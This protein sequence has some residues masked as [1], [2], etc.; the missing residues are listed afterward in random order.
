MI[1]R[2]QQYTISQTALLIREDNLDI[3]LV[4][5]YL[6][7]GSNMGE[8]QENLQKALDYISQRMRI[9]K[10]SSIYDTAP[11]GNINQPRF[12]NMVWGGESMKKSLS[13]LTFVIPNG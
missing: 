6:G 4:T 12:L 2:I 8:K 11:I 10:K 9:E 1:K 7:L 13:F 5:V 3:R